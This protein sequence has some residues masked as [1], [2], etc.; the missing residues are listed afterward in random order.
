M[1]QYVQDKR[2]SPSGI[3]P[4][5]NPLNTATHRAKILDDNLPTV[6]AGGCANYGPTYDSESCA[7]RGSSGATGHGMGSVVRRAQSR[8]E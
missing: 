2:A 6:L 4:S 5:P 1:D 8:G 3:N 7:G